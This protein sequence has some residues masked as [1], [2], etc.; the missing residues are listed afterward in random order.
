MTKEEINRMIHAARGLCWHEF[1]P[2]PR[3][4]GKLDY[5]YLTCKYCRKHIK[6]SE[7]QNIDYSTPEGFFACWNW[8]KEEEWWDDFMD[9]LELR[10]LSDKKLRPLRYHM[11]QL[12]DSLVFASIL[13]KFLKNLNK[14]TE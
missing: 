11:A 7:Q 2:L 3:Q 13:A 8:A 14:G 6:S 12:V 1:E 9:A 10:W 5:D 4:Q